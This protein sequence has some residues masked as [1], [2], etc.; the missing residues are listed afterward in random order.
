MIDEWKMERGVSSS[1]FELE[2][3]EVKGV[4]RWFVGGNRNR[5][6]VLM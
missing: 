2:Y 6:D 1:V 5:R 4:A 3:C